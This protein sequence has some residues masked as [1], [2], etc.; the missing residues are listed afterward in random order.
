MT[1]NE[2]KVIAY[3]MIANAVIFLKTPYVTMEESKKLVYAYAQDLM[4]IRG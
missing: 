4:E 2:K 3:T 1:N